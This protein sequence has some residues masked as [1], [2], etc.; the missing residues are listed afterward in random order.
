[1][2]KIILCLLMCLSCISYT[3]AKSERLIDEVVIVQNEVINADVY[4]ARGATLFI[5][6]K[7][8]VKGNLYNYGNVIVMPQGDLKVGGSLH[9]LTYEDYKKQE[10]KQYQGYDFGIFQNKGK[11]TLNNVII[12]D[13]YLDKQLVIDGTY[14]DVVDLNSTKGRSKCQSNI[15]YDQNVTLGSI[16]TNKDMYILSGANVTL[17]KDV[18]I[19]GDL[20]IYGT[21]TNKAKLKVSGKIYCLHYGI[22]NASNDKK[23]Y[24]YNKGSIKAE[25][26]KVNTSYL[27]K[28]IP[29]NTHSYKNLVVEASLSNNGKEVKRCI[30]CGNTSSEKNIYQIK[31][32][33]LS[34]DSY[35]YDGYVK[36]P[37]VVIKDIKG[38][39]IDSSN[40]KVSYP[41]NAKNVGNYS[42]TIT[43]KNNYKGKVELKYKI[44]PQ[45]LS[46][47][48]IDTI[49]DKTYN[50][51]QQSFNVSVKV[52]NRTLSRN[53]DYLVD[54]VDAINVGKGKVIIKGIG[55]YQGQ[56]E[57][58]FKIKARSIK[59]CKVEFDKEYAYTGN[60]IKPKP[61]ITYEGIKLVEGKD[62]IL[63]YKNN[64]NVGTAKIVIKGI[65][66]FENSNEISY[67]I[68][69]NKKKN[70][71]VSGLQT[72]TY[73]GSGVKQNLV[74][75][76]GNKILKENSDYTLTYKNNTNCGVAS[77]SVKGKGNYQGEKVYY[78][79][80][81]P[82]ESKIESLKA[83]NNK[84]SI[85][86]NSMKGAAIQISYR[87]K[88]NDT[89]KHIYTNDKKIDINNLS[90]NKTYEVKVRH[91]VRMGSETYFNQYTKIQT[92]KIK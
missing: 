54:Y 19:D 18:T 60:S 3:Q 63:S 59:S 69:A 42:A 70:F 52:N 23:G 22:L 81:R 40:Y 51:Y 13:K 73:S 32:V 82:K 24:L 65:N 39:T 14:Y 41:T 53:V 77:V 28:T 20:Y 8:E 71:T 30:H 38:K 7:S 12:N 56:S 62:Y 49:N 64:V 45:D 87:I 72:K 68:V 5:D 48:S 21:L 15:F 4:V 44:T 26:I 75:K 31:S 84:M 46:K 6:G 29:N 27:Q 47:A 17:S 2:K 55:N 11:A 1:M 76:D 9:T 88:G 66:N 57:K 78:Y 92:V 10:M 50:G 91:Y 25:K 79:Q 67:K 16:N 61:I 80:I 74:V 37:S 43:F 86:V 89:W 34:K 90:K 35:V 85:S 58:S 83:G 33:S 36:K